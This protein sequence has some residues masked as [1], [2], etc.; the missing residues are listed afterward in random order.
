MN[1]RLIKQITVAFVFCILI[2]GI[3]YTVGDVL[4]PDPTCYDQK[5]NQKEEGIDCGTVCGK[6][7]ELAI[8]PLE[9]LSSEL[10]SQGDGDFDF[11]GRVRNP[12]TVHGASNVSY[13]IILKAADD[14]EL[15]RIN[16]SFYILPVQTK[17]IVK[18][19][20]KIEGATKADLV[21][22]DATWN[23][24]NIADLRIDFPLI[25]EQ[26]G[27]VALPGVK[28]QIEGVTENRSDFDFDQVDVVVVLERGPGSVAAV[29]TTTINTFLSDTQRYFKVTWPTAISGDSLTP[30]VQA[31]TNVFRNSNFIRRYGTQEEF[32]RYQ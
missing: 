10:I 1:E 23:K 22:K 7:C 9:V 25:R 28:Y 30:T 15:R 2:G 31:S 20:L 32:Q 8:V 11:V 6:S 16:G 17:F 27:T 13:E 19:P 3:T 12:N 4:T 21:I 14:S 29:T 26:H 24:V 5:Q 18:S